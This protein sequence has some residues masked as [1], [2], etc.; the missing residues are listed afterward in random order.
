[1]TPED[2][3]VEP[4]V[5]CQTRNPHPILNSAI[6]CLKRLTKFAQAATSWPTALKSAKVTIGKIDIERNAVKCVQLTK[7]PSLQSSITT[8]TAH[9][10]FP[11]R[12]KSGIR[13]GFKTH[14]FHLTTIDIIIQRHLDGLKEVLK[15]HGRPKVMCITN[16]RSSSFECEPVLGPVMIDDYMMDRVPYAGDSPQAERRLQTMVKDFK[17]NPSTDVCLFE[18]Q[19]VWSSETFVF[20]TA[21]VNFGGGPPAIRRRV[22]QVL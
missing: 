11:E 14:S 10:P 9:P 4:R 17:A 16:L 19:L 12:C 13:L 5:C 6:E 15:T 8:L 7:V 3:Y 1:V 22:V 18:M 21:E 2:V 20:V